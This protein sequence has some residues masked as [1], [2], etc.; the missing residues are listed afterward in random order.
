MNVKKGGKQVAD[1]PAR[2][3]SE[4]APVCHNPQKK[5]GYIEENHAWGPGS[6]PEPNDY[7]VVLERLMGSPELGSKGWVF[8]QYDHMVRINTILLPGGDA[9][10]LR[11]MGTSKAIGMTLDGNGR[12]CYL[13]PR[14]GGKL[15]VAEAARNLVCTGTRPLAITNCLNFGDPENPEVMWQFDEAVEGI[16]EACRFFSTPVTGGNVSFYNQTLGEPIFPTPVIGMVGLL[17]DA[18]TIVT[19][20]FKKEGDLICLIG[21][22]GDHLGGSEYL[23]S[24]HGLIKGAPPRLDL[25]FESKVQRA[26]LRGIE[27]GIIKSAHDCSEGGIAVAL[28]ESCFSPSGL[29]GAEIRMDKNDRVDSMLF[30]ETPSRI[31]IS[32]EEKSVPAWERL[33]TSIA[34]PWQIIGRVGGDTL[35][36][37]PW[38]KSPIRRLNF[39]W[40]RSLPEK[41]T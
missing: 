8:E 24:E 30:G 5:P 19:P 29:M 40:E 23:K 18:R 7:T 2:V 25:N 16:A 32:I 13:D 26:C 27:L 1:I 3:L 36:I 4:D 12:Y 37:G 15:A 11:V 22:I 17:Q 21:E 34:V 41:L 6:L 28:V 39:L 20:W 31:I 14:M 38:I 9:A 35:R 10:V 33:A